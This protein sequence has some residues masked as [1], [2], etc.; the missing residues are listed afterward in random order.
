MSE[1]NPHFTIRI[2]HFHHPMPADPAIEP[3]WFQAFRSDIMSELSDFNAQVTE[4]LDR[5]FNRLDEDVAELR[6]IIEA[7]RA[8][9]EEKAAATATLDRINRHDLDPAFPAVVEPEEPETPD[10]GEPDADA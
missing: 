6:R 8:T 9:D 7:S 2:D 1:P 5:M 4:H 3:A 10:E